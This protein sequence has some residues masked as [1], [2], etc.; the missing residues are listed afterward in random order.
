M[1]RLLL[2]ML[3]GAILLCAT[4]CKKNVDDDTSLP[5]V[6]TVVTPVPDPVIS[7]FITEYN[8]FSKRT[9][10]DYFREE[11][12]KSYKGIANECD[13]YITNDN[14]AAT[15]PGLRISIIGGTTEEDRARMVEVFVDV[16]RVVDTYVSNDLLNKAV[17]HMMAQTG[18]LTNYRFCGYLE[19]ETYMPIVDTGTGVVPCRIDLVAYQYFAE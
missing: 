5:E 13:F 7:R 19:V 18:P 17:D 12:V 8:A 10:H 4:A 9:L 14:D 16:A 2:L 1:K 3:C 11:T 15:N 6:S